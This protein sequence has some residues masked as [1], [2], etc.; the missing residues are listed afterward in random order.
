MKKRYSRVMSEATTLIS[1]LAVCPIMENT[2]GM[3]FLTATATSSC[4]KK[5]F[6]PFLFSS[7]HCCMATGKLAMC[8]FSCR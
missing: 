1:T 5:S 3:A 4:V 2:L 7:I 8:V 6:I